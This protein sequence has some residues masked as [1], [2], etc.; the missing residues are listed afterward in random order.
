VRGVDEKEKE[1]EASQEHKKPIRRGGGEA[2]VRR[3]A[4]KYLKVRGPCRASRAALQRTLRFLSW[5]A[6]RPGCP[7][8]DKRT[9]PTSRRYGGCGSEKLGRR[10]ARGET[11]AEEFS[12]PGSRCASPR[13]G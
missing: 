10:K 1:E 7:R 12:S 4:R 13:L 3:S 5:K 9:W 2:G 6:N 11:G 8:G